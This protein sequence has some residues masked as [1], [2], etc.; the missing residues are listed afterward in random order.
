MDEVILFVEKTSEG[1]LAANRVFLCARSMFIMDFNR[2]FEK[3]VLADGTLFLP[4]Y[5]LML[6][7]SGKAG[8]ITMTEGCKGRDCPCE[9][10]INC[11]RYKR[12]KHPHS[13]DEINEWY[14]DNFKDWCHIQDAF[15]NG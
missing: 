5:D 9:M 12:S 11:S 15:A 13:Y 8:I 3:L 14:D 6:M 2:D 7:R 4:E 1:R 10:W